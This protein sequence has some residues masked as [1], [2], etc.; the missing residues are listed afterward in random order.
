MP[1]GS[2][3]KIFSK[4]APMDFLFQMPIGGGNHPHVNFG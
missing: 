3:P 4:P 1:D 2:I